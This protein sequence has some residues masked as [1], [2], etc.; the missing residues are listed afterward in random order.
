MRRRRLLSTLGA[1]V[2]VGAAGCSGGSERSTPAFR[3]SSPALSDGGTFPAEFTCEG[4]GKSPPLTVDRVPEPTGAL[5]VTAEADL[6]PINEPVFWSLWNVPGDAEKIPAGV[7]RTETVD[8]LGGARQG[9]QDGGEVGYSPPCP[10]AGTTV[11]LRF[12]VYALPE[13]LSADAGALHDT[14]TE[15]LEQVV[16]ASRRLTV[17]YRRPATDTDR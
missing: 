4:A 2:T 16:L 3:A 11:E 1:A 13:P 15:E 14:V 5:A 12:Q 9:R 10:P 6:G 7:P 17:D 8:A